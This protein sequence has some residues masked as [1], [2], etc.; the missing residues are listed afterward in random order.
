MADAEKLDIEGI[1]I[2]DS[3]NSD[4]NEDYANVFYELRKNK[5]V[6]PEQAAETI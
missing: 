4:K 1:E 6:T 5:G 3:E 2:V